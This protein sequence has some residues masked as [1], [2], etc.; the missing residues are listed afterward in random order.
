MSLSSFIYVIR[1]QQEDRRCSNLVDELM[2]IV[3][4]IAAI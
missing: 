1:R 3:A 2:K 4:P